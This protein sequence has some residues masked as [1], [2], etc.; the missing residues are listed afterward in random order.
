[1]MDEIFHL[2]REGPTLGGAIKVFKLIASN[3][4][5]WLE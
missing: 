1:M 2:I 5:G 3:V 4:G